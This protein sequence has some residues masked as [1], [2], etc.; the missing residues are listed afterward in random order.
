MVYKSP[1]KLAGIVLLAPETLPVS[2]IGTIRDHEVGGIIDRIIACILIDGNPLRS[3][4]DSLTVMDMMHRWA[5]GAGACLNLK[6]R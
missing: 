2:E 6:P 4:S 5:I 3:H 1:Q